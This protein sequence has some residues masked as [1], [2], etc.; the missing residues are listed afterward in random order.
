MPNLAQ[1]FASLLSVFL[2]AMVCS[3]AITPLVRAHALKSGAIDVPDSRR[4]HLVPTPRWGGI[5][6]YASILLTVLCIAAV[7]PWLR[8]SLTSA[9]PKL[10]GLGLG[11]TVLLAVGVRDD[12]EG[13]S[14]GVKL[15]AEMSA[16]ILFVL[17]GGGIKSLFG[18]HLGYLSVPATIFWVVALINAFNMIDGLDGLA[19][20]LAIIMSTTLVL[21]SVR[22]GAIVPALIL[23]SVAGALGGFL[24]YNFNPASIFLG[25]SGSLFIGFLMATL[26]VAISDKGSAAT[27]ILVPILALGLPFTELILTTVRRLLGI[28]RVVR[29]REENVSYVFRI[30]GRAA[31]FTPD[32]NH[33][34]HRLLARGLTS[35]RAVLVLYAACLTVNA[36][37]FILATENRT[38]QSLLIMFF[39]LALIACIRALGYD[40]LQPLRKGLLLPL[41]PMQL[42][43]RKS[44]RAAVDLTFAFLSLLAANWIHIS[45]SGGHVIDGYFTS[46]F[47]SIAVVQTILLGVGGLYHRDFPVV[48]TEDLLVLVRSISF[49]SLG[50]WALC[51]IFG[52]FLIPGLEVMVLDLCILAALLGAFRFSFI[53]MDYSFNGTNK[54]NPPVVMVAQKS[55]PGP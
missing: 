5:A 36:G 27:T 17:V 53:L 24:C 28:V 11:A 14:P 25:D 26:S 9:M 35:R 51:E 46:K 23:A 54:N 31:L 13:V 44:L 1:N 43:K 6:V 38:H 41:L 39:L 40:E 32:K 3:L 2:F 50:T 55:T 47:L 21:L 30:V 49:A 15:A 18:I 33:I 10:V 48:D 7:S 8:L 34:H 52:P 37:A 42:L 12:R 45:G 22:A 20:G 29:S 4:I 19:S 16:A